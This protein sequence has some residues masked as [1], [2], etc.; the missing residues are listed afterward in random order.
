MPRY[1]SLC[2]RFICTALFELSLQMM[3][4]SARCRLSIQDFFFP[5]D[6]ENFLLRP[7]VISMIMVTVPIPGLLLVVRS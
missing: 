5:Y 7:D 3:T 4:V 6:M 1:H 2:A